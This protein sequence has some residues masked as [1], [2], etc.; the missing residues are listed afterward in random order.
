MGGRAVGT[1]NKPQPTV[2]VWLDGLL[3]KRRR[4]IEQWVECGEK[5]IIAAVLVASAL[6]KVTEALNAAAG[7]LPVE[8][9]EEPTEDTAEV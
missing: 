9:A 5:E 6:S 7:V 3:N 1:K 2:G 4:T 8:V